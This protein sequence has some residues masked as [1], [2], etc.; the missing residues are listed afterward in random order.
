MDHFGQI[1]DLLGIFCST[2]ICYHCLMVLLAALVHRSKRHREAL[3]EIKLL[4]GGSSQIK[5]CPS[6]WGCFSGLWIQTVEKAAW[7]AFQW[8]QS[9][10]LEGGLDVRQRTSLKISNDIGSSLYYLSI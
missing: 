8:L 6:F 10:M 3:G 7:L 1:L 4:S 2:D 9:V 5:L